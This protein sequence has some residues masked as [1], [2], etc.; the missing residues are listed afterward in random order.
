MTVWM[1]DPYG[2][3][4]G[5]YTLLVAPSYVE[6]SRLEVYPAKR[7]QGYGRLVLRHAVEMVR[8]LFPEAR[9]YAIVKHRN[10]PAHT[11][12]VRAGFKLLYR[13]ELRAENEYVLIGEVSA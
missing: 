4:L 1:Y 11:L 9:L 2:T 3:P 8:R 7:G 13:D 10:D 6:I 5:E 12:F